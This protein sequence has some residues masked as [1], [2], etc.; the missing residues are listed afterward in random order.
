M[1]ERNS[2]VDATA[3][4]HQKTTKKERGRILHEFTQ[5][6]HYGRKY[7]AGLLTGVSDPAER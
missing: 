6:A 7:A 3:K 2:V 4:R 1:R 5:V